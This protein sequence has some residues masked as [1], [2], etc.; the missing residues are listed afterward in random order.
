MGFIFK[1]AG[2]KVGTGDRDGVDVRQGGFV[3]CYT[4]PLCM[5]K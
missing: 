1:T 4:I 2:A 3:V 5:C